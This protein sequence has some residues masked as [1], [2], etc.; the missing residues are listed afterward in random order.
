MGVQFIVYSLTGIL[1]AG[2]EIPE[3]RTWHTFTFVTPSQAVMYGGL[4]QHN[5]VLSKFQWLEY[6]LK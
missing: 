6:I 1:D 3:G 2:R 5:A 4:S